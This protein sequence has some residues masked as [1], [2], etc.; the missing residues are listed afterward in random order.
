MATKTT[1]G[2]AWLT[3]TPTSGT[4][5][6]SL[7]IQVTPSAL[8]A[9]SYT[10]T[11]TVTSSSAAS[12]V[13]IQVTLTVA[14]IPAPVIT[15]IGNAA[16]YAVGAVSPGEN[17]VIFGTNIGPTPLVSGK[18]TAG[19]FETTAGD[20]QVFFDGVAAPVLYALRGRPA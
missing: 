12:P 14:A 2:G 7:S 16:S 4:A 1:D 10:G 18:V 8:A 20:T 11:V 13:T 19:A 6:A 9:G 17:I 15:A 3:A 5:P